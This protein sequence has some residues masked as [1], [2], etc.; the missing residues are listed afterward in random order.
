MTT[1]PSRRA[2]RTAYLE[3]LLPPHVIERD[4][5]TGGLLRPLLGHLAEHPRQRPG[6]DPPLMVQIGREE[7]A[8]GEVGGEPAAVEVA[9]HPV[10]AAVQV[11]RSTQRQQRVTVVESHAARV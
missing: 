7:V 10:G 8:R 3:G 4:A 9:D 5:E 11:E 2:D 1:S 6:E